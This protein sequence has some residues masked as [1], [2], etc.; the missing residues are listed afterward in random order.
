M[1][2]SPMA[3]AIARAK[4]PRAFFVSSA[5]V[6]KGEPDPF[7]KVVLEEHQM[8]LPP[9]AP[10][11]LD[12]LGDD[13][14]DLIVVLAPEAHEKALELS[15]GKSLDVEYWPLP[16]PSQTAGT[17]AQILDAYRAVRDALEIKIRTYFEV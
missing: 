15:R 2:R 9:H 8:A 11:S 4:L 14:F 3:E 12:E 13:Y 1:I 17:R 5:G 16:D 6:T 7:V 10:H